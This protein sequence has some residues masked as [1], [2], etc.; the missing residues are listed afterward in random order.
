MTTS[1]PRALEILT[2][3][4]LVAEDA[5]PLPASRTRGANGAAFTVSKMTMS[6]SLPWKRW[7]GAAFD[8][9]IQIALR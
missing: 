6:R 2:L 7:H 9:S 1:F 3:M 8:V 5:A 4:R